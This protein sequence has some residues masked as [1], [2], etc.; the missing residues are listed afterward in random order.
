MI[1]P[2]KSSCF[3]YLPKKYYILDAIKKRHSYL[4]KL[5]VNLKPY[6]VAA[7]FLTFRV[8]YSF[9]TLQ[10]LLFIPIEKN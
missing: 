10:N 1:T 5:I 2:Y 4:D 8:F 7:A 6:Q 3:P 9:S